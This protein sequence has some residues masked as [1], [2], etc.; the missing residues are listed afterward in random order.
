MQII[1]RLNNSPFQ[2]LNMR[3]EDGELI[4]LAFSYAQSQETWTMAVQYLNVRYASIAVV[5]SPN[6]LLQQKNVLPFGIFVNTIDG[7]DPYFIDDFVNGRT[8]V[9]LLTSEEVEI[10]DSVNR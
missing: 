3:S 10:L 6:L 2:S 7:F 1:N 9:G 5:N 8:T 4:Q